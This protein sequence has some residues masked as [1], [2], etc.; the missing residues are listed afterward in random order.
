[1]Q[2]RE[3]EIYE[4]LVADGLTEKYGK[5]GIYCIKID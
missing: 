5:A 1:M 2:G 4:Q 3:L